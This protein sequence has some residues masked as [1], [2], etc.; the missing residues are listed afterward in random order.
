MT[1]ELFESLL[2]EEEGTEIDF[3][4]EQYPFVNATDDDKSELLKDIIGFANAWRRSKA[5]IL[6]GVEEVRGDK[7]IVI[8]IAASEQLDDHSLQQ[9]VN[10]IVNKPVHFQYRAFTYEGKQVGIIV[11]DEDQ[12][13][14]IYLKRNY[15]KL[16]M[17]KV[18]VRWG[19]STNLTRP[20]S[21]DEIAR[22]GAGRPR[23]RAELKV[24]FA[25]VDRD[26]SIGTS[27]QMEC[28]FCDVPEQKDIP[29]LPDS[30]EYPFGIKTDYLRVHNENY[31]RELAEYEF[32]TRLCRPTRITVTNVGGVAAQN[33]RL[34]VVVPMGIGLMP[35]EYLPKKPAKESYGGVDMSHAIR[36]AFRRDPG[37]VEIDRNDDRFR[38][39][40]DCKDLQPGRQVWSDKFYVGMARS[41]DY[42]LHGRVFADNLPTPQEF[43]LTIKADVKNTVL[44]LKQLRAIKA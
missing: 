35:V 27:V 12:P 26:N 28:E 41:G 25:E 18:Y 24:E 30:R 34:E 20:A 43:S 40:I 14:P 6:I 8:G 22:M 33:V 23:E 32:M 19:S 37:E 3:K 44:S 36:P 5:Y 31:Y 21:L 4:K 42:P 16:E 15:G 10:S 9:F 39:E 1:N 38:I 13:R 17:E 29:K 2:Y 11:L 7:S